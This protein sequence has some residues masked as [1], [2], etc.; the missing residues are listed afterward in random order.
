MHH[1]GQ[2]Q[3]LERPHIGRRDYDDCP[4]ILDPELEPLLLLD[5]LD[6]MV[7]PHDLDRVRVRPRPDSDPMSP[8][9]DSAITTAGSSSVTTQGG[10]EIGDRSGVNGETLGELGG[11]AKRKVVEVGGVG[12]GEEE[13]EDKAGEAEAENET[14]EAAKS[15]E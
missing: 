8:D 3:R 9:D 1:A 11:C 12:S 7:R 10:V 4:R 2:V 6:D 14:N 5:R 15:V 13:E